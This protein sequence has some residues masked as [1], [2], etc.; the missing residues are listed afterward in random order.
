MKKNTVKKIV[1]LGLVLSVVMPIAAAAAVPVYETN[2]ILLTDGKINP[3]KASITAAESIISAIWD[4]VT[5]EQ[6]T[7]KN[8]FDA[9]VQ[10]VFKIALELFKIFVLN[11]MADSIVEFVTGGVGGD[12]KMIVNWFGFLGKEA[13]KS[14]YGVISQLDNAVA[15]GLLCSPFAYQ[16]QQAMRP[17]IP[18]RGLPGGSFQGR[19][20]CSLDSFVSN[21]NQFYRDFSVGGWEAYAETI[22]PNNNFFGT[23]YDSLNTEEMLAYSL[24]EGAR[25]EGLAGQGF[26]GVQK[27]EDFGSGFPECAI[28]TQGKTIA[29]TV[30][31]A[32]GERFDYIVNIQQMLDFSTIFGIASSFLSKLINS[33]DDGFLSA[34]IATPIGAPLPP[35]KNCSLLPPGPERDACLLRESVNSSTVSHLECISNGCISVD[36]PGPDTCSNAGF[37][38]DVHL[39][40]L[41][42]ACIA[43]AGPGPDACPTRGQ[44]CVAFI[45]VVKLTASPSSIVLGNSAT[46]IWTTNNP[47][48]CTASDG[49]S[50]SKNP[51]GGSEVVTPSATTVYSLTCTDVDGSSMV[52]AVVTV[53]LPPPPP[54]AQTHLECA[55]IAC[56]PVAGPG[57]DLCLTDIDCQLG[58]P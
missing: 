32:A 48:Q 8:I 34:T 29:E 14:L 50:G 18:V 58:S 56:T 39:E 35:T 33:G 38:C 28:T 12:P 49:W 42:N 10:W 41:N 43:V 5:G 21:I 53:T 23:F 52:S 9:W 7:L 31:R 15:G 40:C 27:C 26:L 25:N 36:G 19:L 57:P 47:I 22:L 54:P 20:T 30:D 13:E 17:P 51:L 44:T 6:T 24:Q 11:N 4:L 3:V 55:F 2:P 45:P 1:A 16:L 46:L 37:A